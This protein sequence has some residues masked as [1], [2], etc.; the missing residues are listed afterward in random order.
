MARRPSEERVGEGLDM[1]KKHGRVR[2]PPKM[3]EA[4]E[5]SGI[6]TSNSRVSSVNTNDAI[7]IL[8]ILKCM[9]TEFLWV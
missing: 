1:V 9:V 5:L 2:E 8:F 6:V 3:V 4:G 7:F